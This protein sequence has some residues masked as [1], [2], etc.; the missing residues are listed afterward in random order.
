M[1]LNFLYKY[2]CEFITPLEEKN[3][4][5]LRQLDLEQ[6]DTHGVLNKQAEGKKTNT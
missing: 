1:F 2:C 4:V 5:A 6:Y 3:I